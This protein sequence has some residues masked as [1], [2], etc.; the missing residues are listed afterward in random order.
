MGQ[1]LTVFNSIQICRRV[2]IYAGRNVWHALRRLQH[3]PSRCTY[4]AAITPT[5]S[6]GLWACPNPS[7]FLHLCKQWWTDGA[8]ILVLSQFSLIKMKLPFYSSV[9]RIFDVNQTCLDLRPPA[10]ATIQDKEHTGFCFFEQSTSIVSC[11]FAIDSS[12]LNSAKN[13]WLC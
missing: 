1:N 6:W 11:P 10:S 7:N 4:K 9:N 13:V 8:K 2:E 12:V 5:N 3:C